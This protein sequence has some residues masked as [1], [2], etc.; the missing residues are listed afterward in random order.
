[1]SFQ[2]GISGLSAT[3]K[4]LDV[5]GNNIANSATIGAKSSR[6]E[7]ADMYSSALGSGSGKQ[8]GVGVAVASVA[9]SFSQ[10]S[11]TSTSNPLD[12][13][14]S[15]NGFFQ[16]KTAEGAVHYTRNGQFKLN[17][18]GD[19][20]NNQGNRLMG[21]AADASGVVQSGQAQPLQ[22]QT[23]AIEPKATSTVGIS[24][25]LDSRGGL[26][27]PT[28]AWNYVAAPGSNPSIDFNDA[29]TYNNATSVTAVDAN[30]KDVVLTSYFQKTG[31]DTWDVYMTANGSPVGPVQ[32]VAGPP[33]VDSATP[34]TTLSFTNAG[35]LVSATGAIVPSVA[36]ISVDIPAG[37]VINGVGT[38]QIN[39]LKVDLNNFT[40]F[41]APFGV[42]K[43]SQNGFSAGSLSG[44]IVESSGLIRANYSNG[45]TKSIGQIEMA[46]FSNMNGLQPLGGNE[47]AQTINAGDPALG[48]PGSGSLGTLQTSALEESNV[49]LTGELVNMMIA[50]RTYQAN[51]QTIKTQDQVLQTLVNLR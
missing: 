21:Y 37:A 26:T 18:D 49:D 41:A 42:T 17:R 14:I 35:V 50:Q 8:T 24:A 39:G 46:T 15:G 2:Q 40:E 30:G 34:V 11:I 3:S 22:L 5:I 33:A 20:V 48:V 29:S 10:G 1:M 31:P 51:A 9:Q 32:A 36:T 47:W 19:I 6:I 43:L 45:R 7:F 27:Q 23:S 4:N 12:L 13:A 16:V 44:V 28:T 25:N 38:G